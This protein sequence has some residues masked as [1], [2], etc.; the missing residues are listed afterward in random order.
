MIR[1]QTVIKSL[2]L[3]SI[4][5]EQIPSLPSKQMQLPSMTLLKLKFPTIFCFLPWPSLSSVRVHRELT[6]RWDANRLVYP[7]LSRGKTKHEGDGGGDDSVRQRR[8]SP[9]GRAR[10]SRRLAA[11]PRR[12]ISAGSKRT[13]PGRLCSR[14]ARCT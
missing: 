11:P 5:F 2:K 4:I 10:G 3:Y 6:Y 9:E 7:L 8:T 13:S 12:R 14:E 1:V